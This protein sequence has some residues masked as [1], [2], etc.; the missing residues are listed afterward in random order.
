MIENE[1]IQKLIERNIHVFDK[2]PEELKTK[3]RA[4]LD[5][6]RELNTPTRLGNMEYDIKE[7]TIKN[8]INTLNT[9]YTTL[10]F[11]LEEEKSNDNP[12]R[13]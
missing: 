7:E 4:N 13:P 12:F 1:H 10:G 11:T 9:D 3:Y 8:I 2:C 6:A 5:W